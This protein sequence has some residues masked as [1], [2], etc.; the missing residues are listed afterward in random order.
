MLSTAMCSSISLAADVSV[1][2]WRWDGQRFG[3]V[4]V[5]KICFEFQVL[6]VE[7]YGEIQKKGI[8]GMTR[9]KRD[10]EF[11]AKTHH[12]WSG[13]TDGAFLGVRAVTS[14]KI[15]IPVQLSKCPSRTCGRPVTRFSVTRYNFR[16]DILSDL[17]GG[18]R[19]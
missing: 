5:T 17:L 1:E 9:C 15:A 14:W 2:V 7:R 10:G 6:E 16:R 4:E 19:K 11:T 13:A 3:E 18:R 12:F 8:G